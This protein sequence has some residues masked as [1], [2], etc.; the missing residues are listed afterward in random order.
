MEVEE[1]RT[2]LV[3]DAVSWQSTQ[4]GKRIFRN[5]CLMAVLFSANHGTIVSCLS[6]ATARLGAVGALQSGVLYLFYTLSAVLGATYVVTKVGGRNGMVAGMILYCVYVA[7][8]LLAT[9]YPELERAAALT[10]ATFGGIGAGFLWVAQGTYFAEA[11]KRHAAAMQQEISES[12]SFFAGTFACIYLSFEVVLRTLSSLLALFLDWRAIFG[13]YTAIAVISTVGM[14]LVTNYQEDEDGSRAPSSMFYKV[15]AALRLLVKDPKMKYMI[16]LNATFGFTGAFLNSYVNGQVIAA[17]LNDTDS[18]YV[19]VLSSITAVVAALVSLAT[20]RIPQKG[21][22]LIGGAV[23]FFFVAFPFLVQPDATLWSLQGLVAI[24]TLQGI[25]R[26]TYES[27]LKA[28]FADYFSSDSVG[29]FGNM[30]LQNGLAGSIGYILTFRLLCDNPSRYC[31]EY[32]DGT[33]HDVLTFVLV[34]CISGIIAVLG[35]WRASVLYK[36]EQEGYRRP[37]LVP[38][39]DAEAA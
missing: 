28:T 13:I 10:G 24:Y 30:I 33:L 11:S 37:A 23:C 38:N 35:F 9:V 17:A 29:A 1:L 21:P 4:E 27:T 31:V 32:S 22:L 8:F 36:R 34:V 14:L 5:F 16:G 15:T 18:H 26:A 2:N 25:G 20:G 19:G 6:L 12:T 3:E 39:D 7:C